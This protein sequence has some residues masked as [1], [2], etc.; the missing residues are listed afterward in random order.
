[1]H[2]FIVVVK[3]MLW[4]SNVFFYKHLYPNSAIRNIIM[5]SGIKRLDNDKGILIFVC[6]YN[7]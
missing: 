7:N 3:K 6:T 2:R 4:Y 1:M 5:E